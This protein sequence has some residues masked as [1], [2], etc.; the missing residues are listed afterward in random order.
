MIYFDNV[1]AC[2]ADGVLKM[3]MSTRMM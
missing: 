3:E 2:L 1:T